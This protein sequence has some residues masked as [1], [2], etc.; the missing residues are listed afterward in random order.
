MV[1][2]GSCVSPGQRGASG[3]RDRL[4]DA[5]GSMATALWVWGSPWT[6]R[7]LSR[8]I[9]SLRVSRIHRRSAGPGRSGRSRSRV[10][11]GPLSL[12]RLGLELPILPALW[13]V[14]KLV[15]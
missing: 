11:R 14:I 9:P 10:R 15:S 6:A 5:Q 7:E 8:P 4:R 2:P 1:A 12:A 3:S 13:D